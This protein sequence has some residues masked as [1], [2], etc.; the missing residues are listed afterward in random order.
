MT[1]CTCG[2]TSDH[3]IARRMLATGEI[4]YFWSDGTVTWGDAGRTMVR[5]V[6]RARY[7]YRRKADRRANEAIMEIAHEIDARD[8]GTAIRAARA[9]V[10]NGGTYDDFPVRIREHIRACL[11]TQPELP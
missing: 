11:P 4:V 1:D 10:R 2:D 9:F 3:E 8:L 7:N 5:G 6:G